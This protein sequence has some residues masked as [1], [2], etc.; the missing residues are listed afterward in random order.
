LAK[1]IS[2]N[3]AFNILGEHPQA[4]LEL[5]RQGC[6]KQ[7]ILARSNKSIGVFDASFTIEAGEIFVISA[8]IKSCSMAGSRKRWQRARNNSAIPASAGI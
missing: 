4:A 1:Q 8:R 7:E 6:S 3:N 2:I 5:V